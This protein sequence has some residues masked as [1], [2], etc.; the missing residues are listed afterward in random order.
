MPPPRIALAPAGANVAIKW[1]AAASGW[2]LESSETLVAASW[3]TVSTASG[4][5]V[6]SGV[7]TLEELMSGPRKFYRLRR[8]P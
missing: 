2:V 1:P 6:E 4:V 8:A 7:A 5:T 3:Q